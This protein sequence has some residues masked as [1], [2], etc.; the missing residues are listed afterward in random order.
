V[1]SDMGPVT[2]LGHTGFIGRYLMSRYA[3]LGADVSGFSSATLDLRD[4][5]AFGA[6]DAATGP[7]TTLFVASTITPDRG[8]TRDALASNFAMMLNL[9]R[10]LEGH[11]VHKCVYLSSD[12]VY[13]MTAEPVTES[14]AVEPA[15]FYALAKYAGERV[16]QSVADSCGFPLLIVRPTGIYGPGD[17]HNSYGPNRFIRGVVG[18]GSVRLF[19]AGEETRD[20][21]YID[22]LIEI[23][24]ALAAS[25]LAGVFNAATGHSRTFASIVESLR[26]MAGRPIEQV[27]LP[28]QGAI[29]HR[30]FN[31]SRLADALPG[32]AFT[33][34]EE[35]L[36]KSLAAARN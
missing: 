34:F 14:S 35:G 20:H 19:G 10:Y 15:N 32:L 7:R 17:T 28:R 2:V 13:P 6:L 24:V 30:Q 4:A 23:L 9:A 33:P 25:D 3:G 18:D 16:L 29:T 27:N 8:T 22:D 21:L 26:K 12:A 5:D 31:I 11:P 36:R 1:N